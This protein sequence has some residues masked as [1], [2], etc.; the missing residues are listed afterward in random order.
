MEIPNNLKELREILRKDFKIINFGLPDPTF[1]PGGISRTNQIVRCPYCKNEFVQHV[2]SGCFI[3]TKSP[4]ECP[5]CGF[6]H[7]FREKYWKI[8]KIEELFSALDETTIEYIIN[9]ENIPEPGGVCSQCK[10]AIRVFV[11]KGN[12][13]VKCYLNQKKKEE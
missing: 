1:T 12:L 5:K 13:C 8:K 3:H 10:K 6:P 9:F 4:T 2:E 11:F 7:K